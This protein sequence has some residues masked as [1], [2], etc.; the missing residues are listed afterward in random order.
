MKKTLILLTALI[1]VV[2]CLLAL[3]SCERYEGTPYKRD[4]DLLNSE[5]FCLTIE[6]IDYGTPTEIIFAK[7]DGKIVLITD[8]TNL[9]TLLTQNGGYFFDVE[10]KTY[11]DFNKTD[12]NY[13]SLDIGH[14]TIDSVE[15]EDGNTI[16]K[17]NSK[18]KKDVELI[19]NGEEL[20]SISISHLFNLPQSATFD[21]VS[22][23]DEIPEYCF[24]EIPEDYEYKADDTWIG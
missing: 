15:Q 6:I 5:S 4:V 24:F 19:Y 7:K 1:T 16:A 2:S 11:Y 22:L 9:P 3:T 8:D 23:S 18:S 17:C 13:K 14:L 20:Q 10:K 12:L 21:V